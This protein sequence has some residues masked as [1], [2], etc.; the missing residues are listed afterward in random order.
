MGSGA[1][2]GTVVAAGTASVLVAGPA[3]AGAAPPSPAN[4]D[5]KGFAELPPAA[6]L[7][8]S[9]AV[10]SSSGSY[11]GT[12]RMRSGTAH[13]YVKESAFRGSRI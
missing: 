10:A 5:A 1:V 11:T 6:A 12:Q 3:E 9:F 7:A 4:R 13:G 8:A 2:L